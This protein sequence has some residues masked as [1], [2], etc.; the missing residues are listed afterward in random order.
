M[1]IREIEFSKLRHAYLV[2]KSFLD[3][4]S[5]EK[6]NSLNTR[7]EEDLGIYGDDTSEFLERFVEK[8]QLDYSGF[9]YSKHFHSEGELFDPAFAFIAL[10]ELSIWIPLKTIELLTLNKVKLDRPNWNESRITEDL[11]FKDLIVWYIEKE[12]KT[13]KEISYQLKIDSKT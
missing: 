11:T 4:E 3:S 10:L 5:F 6:V 13:S 7:V 2:V 8:F 1:E 12:F 9:E